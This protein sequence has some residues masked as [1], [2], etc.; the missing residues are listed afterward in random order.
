MVIKYVIVGIL[1]LQKF[2]IFQQNAQMMIMAVFI[3]QGRRVNSRRQCWQFQRYGGF[4]D[5]TLM[6]SFSD[7]DF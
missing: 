1:A 7:G 3:A 2:A 4:L 5:Q 6:G